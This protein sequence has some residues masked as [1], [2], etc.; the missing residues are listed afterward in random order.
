MV[1]VYPFWVLDTQRHCNYQALHNSQH[2]FQCHVCELLTVRRLAAKH[3][4]TQVRAATLAWRDPEAAAAQHSRGR[5]SQVPA[6]K[7]CAACACRR[8]DK[9][10]LQS[11]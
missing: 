3:L 7:V 2:R 5:P 8:S 1:R 4:R 6:L 9:S 10:Q 11:S